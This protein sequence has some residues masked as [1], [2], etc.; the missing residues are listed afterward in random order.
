MYVNSG[1]GGGGAFFRLPLLCRLL[2]WRVEVGKFDGRRMML[3]GV[4]LAGG[5]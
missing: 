1:T 2:S 4:S 5:F 3:H